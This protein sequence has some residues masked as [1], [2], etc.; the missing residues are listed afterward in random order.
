ML[1]FT[2]SKRNEV[3]LF[4]VVQQFEAILE[5]VKHYMNTVGDT[6][7][8]ISLL[9]SMNELASHISASLKEGVIRNVSANS[10]NSAIHKAKAWHTSVERFVHRLRK[11]YPLYCDLLGPFVAGLSQVRLKA[12]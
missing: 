11:E 10:V 1:L 4:N 5:E 12:K 6:N 2:D 7:T 8:V 3:M 9:D